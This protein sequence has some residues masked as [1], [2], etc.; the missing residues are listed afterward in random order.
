MCD[1]YINDVILTALNLSDAPLHAVDRNRLSDTFGIVRNSTYVQ[2]R[3]GKIPPPIK[4]PIGS[5]FWYQYETDAMLIAMADP[6]IDPEEITA[7]L[8]DARQNLPSI[9]QEAMTLQIQ[10]AAPA[11]GVQ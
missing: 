11:G 4:P 5:K 7:A 2:Q 8:I 10:Q 9:I 1:S 6:N 3:R